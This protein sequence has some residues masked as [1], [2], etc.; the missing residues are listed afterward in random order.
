DPEKIPYSF[1][2]QLDVQYAVGRIHFNTLDE[3]ANYAKSVVT[4][5][6]GRIRLPR[7]ATFFGV[8]NHGDRATQLSSEILVEPVSEMLR[9]Q[10][11]EWDIAAY[12]REQATKSQLATL[13][14]GDQTPAFLMSASHGVAFPSGDAQQLP[15]Q[16]ALL[17]QD[18]P[19]PGSGSIAREWYFAGQDLP[20]DANLL[21]LI[22]FFF[23]CFG[24]GTPRLDQF[25]KEAGRQEREQIAPR[26]FLAR[27]PAA[28]LSQSNGGALAV[29]GQVDR[30]WGY[31]FMWPGAGA[32]TEVFLS[33][34]RR[35]LEGHP[36]GSAVEYLNERYAELSTV[37]SDILEEIDF[38][39]PADAYEL[40]GLWTANNDARGLTIIGDPAVRLPVA[41]LGEERISGRRPEQIDL[42]VPEKAPALIMTSRPTIQQLE[43]QPKFIEQLQSSKED[44]RAKGLAEA[45]KIVD[46]TTEIRKKILEDENLD[47]DALPDAEKEVLQKQ[48]ALDREVSRLT[49]VAT[50]QEGEYADGER[51]TALSILESLG[52]KAG[53]RTLDKLKTAARDADLAADVRAMLLPAIMAIDN[54]PLAK[55]RF[56]ELQLREGDPPVQRAVMDWLPQFR[57]VDPETQEEL[58]RLAS[59]EDVGKLAIE[60]L[61]AVEPD[62]VKLMSATIARLGRG[63]LPPQTQATLGTE[64]LQEGKAMREAWVAGREQRKPILSLILATM[65]EGDPEARQKAVDWLAARAQEVPSE[66]LDGTIAELT[67]ATLTEDEAPIREQINKLSD[68][69][70]E[71]KKFERNVLERDLRHAD[72]SVRFEAIKR[73]AEAKNEWPLRILIKEWVRWIASGKSTDVQFIEETAQRMRGN[74][75]AV[76][77]LLNALTQDFQPTDELV[78]DVKETVSTLT[79]GEVDRATIVVSDEGTE[80]DQELRKRIVTVLEEELNNRESNVYQTVLKRMSIRN[81]TNLDDEAI[82]RSIITYIQ[83]ELKERELWV[84]RRIS[85]QLSEMSNPHYFEETAEGGK[86]PEHEAIKRQLTRYGVPVLA[87]ILPESDDDEV[88]ENLAY[89]LG[90]VGGRE[91]IDALA[92]AVV[93]EERTRANRQKLL[94]TYYLEPSKQRS[95]EASDILKGAVTAAKRTLLLQQLLNVLVLVVGLLILIGGLLFA[96]Q[97]TENAQRIAGILVGLGGFAGILIKM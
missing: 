36:I 79:S 77:P 11:P 87:R 37:L 88:R 28:M 86:S 3:Y 55:Q 22:A 61:F 89:T 68:A 15:Y 62:A 18:W 43:E 57:P 14:G 50:A 12:M 52:S 24:G 93:G 31:S 64:F 83:A 27:L 21:G 25:A 94:S 54:D 33:T 35:L 72:S 49:N 9:E 20:A 6:S 96:S 32:Q 7:K 92:R 13:L 29:V 60:T 82:R 59:D 23:A 58:W 84:H 46:E 73:A 45:L 47:E 78:K 63:T 80:A 53:K 26:N 2:T 30:A 38:G 69:L 5:E 51:E 34:F 85:R 41:S 48:R 81:T 90:N 39:M 44:E 17:C 71:R 66:R 4:A 91:S 8:A 67:H 76:L 70:T 40:A 42:A 74:E 65:S 56:L 10:H 16:G 75:V 19:G 97:S 95:D 1:Q